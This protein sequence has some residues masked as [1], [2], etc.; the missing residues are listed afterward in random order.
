MAA[1]LF[2]SPS[3]SVRAGTAVLPKFRYGARSP[4]AIFDWFLTKLSAFFCCFSALLLPKMDD[5]ILPT[6][7]MPAMIVIGSIIRSSLLRIY[8]FVELGLQFIDQGH[9]GGGIGRIGRGHWRDAAKSRQ[10]LTDKAPE[11]EPGARRKPGTGCQWGLSAWRLKVFGHQIAPRGLISALAWNTARSTG[12]EHENRQAKPCV[13]N[14]PRR[15]K[16]TLPR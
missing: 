9:G 5:A 14:S 1:S 7:D 11:G 13:A 6:A 8:D 2:P 4:R 3:A 12:A 10:S 16:R 15:L